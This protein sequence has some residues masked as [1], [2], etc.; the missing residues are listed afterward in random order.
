VK[1]RQDAQQLV[2]G[3]VVLRHHVAGVA[4]HPAEVVVSQ[5]HALGRAGRAGGVWLGG[6]I[7]IGAV[8]GLHGLGGQEL[9]EPGG[10]L[11][12]AVDRDH[13]FDAVV[14]VGVL[15]DRLD[16]GDKI[17]E[18]DDRLGLAVREHVADLAGLVLGVHRDDRAAGPEHAVVGDDELREVREVDADAVAGLQARVGQRR[19]E[20]AGLV[21]ELLV[22]DPLAPEGESRLVGIRLDRLRDIGD[23]IRHHLEEAPAGG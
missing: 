6:D 8:D 14:D 1:E 13:R 9:L 11:G 21:P 5:E 17:R 4:G 3:A 20:L 23:E 2:L 10:T 22:G 12:L 15:A 18:A 7:V 16:E 19:R